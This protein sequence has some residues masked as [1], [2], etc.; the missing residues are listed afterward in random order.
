VACSFSSTVA[1]IW[2]SFLSLPSCSAT[3]RLLVQDTIAAKLLDALKKHA[4]AIVVSDPLQREPP[5]RMG[6][7]VNAAQY[8]KVKGMIAQARAAAARSGTVSWDF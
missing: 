2:S 7:L 3:S 4:E 1:R 8:E 6:P 5:C